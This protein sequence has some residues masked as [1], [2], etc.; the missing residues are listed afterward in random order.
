MTTEPD[1]KTVTETCAEP[2]NHKPERLSDRV[3]ARG[4]LP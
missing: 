4:L 3:L 2:C 1:H